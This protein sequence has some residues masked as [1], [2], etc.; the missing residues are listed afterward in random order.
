M[1][2]AIYGVGG[3]AGYFGARLVEAGHDV[4][5]I[6]R[7]E[8]LEAIRRDGLAIDSPLGNARVKPRIATAD[9]A[10]VGTVDAVLLGVK[11]WQVSDAARALSPLLGPDTAV[12]PLQN[13]I[14][15]SDQIAAVAGSSHAL[16]GT[17]RIISARIAPGHIAHLGAD[18]LIELGELDGSRSPRVIALHAALAGAPGATAVIADDIRARQW[19]KFLFIAAWSGIAALMRAPVGIVRG[20]PESRQL[21]IAGM[22]EIE[23]LARTRRIAL[24]ADAVETAL[25]YLDA[26]PPTGTSSLQRDI[27]AGIP[28]E[29]DSFSGA[30]CRLGVAE[31]VATPVHQLLYALLAPVERHARGMAS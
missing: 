20:A 9:P 2:F 15:A 12:V 19:A 4:A 24:P 13:G 27:A 14:E 8:H 17:A 11:A 16:G 29:I 18:P 23:L 26:L 28:S 1:R 31:N 7:G 22:R 6:A 25:A 5:L 10:E 30:V 3:A 21:V